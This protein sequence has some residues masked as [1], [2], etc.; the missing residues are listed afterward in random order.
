MHIEAEQ[1][2]VLIKLGRRFASPDAERLGQTLESLAPFS[3]LIMDFTDV[4]EF[5]DASFFSLLKALPALADVTVVLRGL[6]LHQ[7]RLMKYLGLPYA[8][9]RARA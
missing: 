1:G 8:E 5:P 3:Q 6:T 9:V 4:R 7:S 2:T